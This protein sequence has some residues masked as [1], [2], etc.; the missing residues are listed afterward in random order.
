[1]SSLSGAAELFGTIG[2]PNNLSAEQIQQSLNQ[3]RFAFLFAPTFHPAMRHV[4]PVR[5]EL[6]IR[7][8][9][10]LIGPLVNPARV[11]KYLIGIFDKSWML[12]YA[13]ILQSNGVTDAW[14]VRGH[15][16]ID[17]IS[18]CGATDITELKNGYIR[19]FQIHPQDVGL[20]TCSAQDI[21][22]AN[23]EANSHILHDVLSGKVGPKRDIVVLNA[24]AALL[25]AGAVDS[26]SDGVNLAAQ[27]IDSGAARDFLQNYVA[28]ISASA[29]S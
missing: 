27:V 5:Q 9:F 8:I 28:A 3:H 14:V 17:E 23:A 13:R 19:Q 22:G 18:L 21:C 20:A 2:I 7:T 24:G 15:D 25:V 29:S 4:A 6:K 16:G 1:M 10:N 12:P 11:K 26:L